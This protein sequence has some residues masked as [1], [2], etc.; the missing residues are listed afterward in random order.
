MKK[1][2]SLILTLLLLIP[3]IFYLTACKNGDE[4]P[5]TQ[6][7][8]TDIAFSGAEQINT[9]EMGSLLYVEFPNSK[10]VLSFSNYITVAESSTWSV[11][12]DIYGNIPITSKTVNLEEGDNLYYI[13]VTAAN[14]N[15][16][17]YI[18]MIHRNYLYTVNFVTGTDTEIDTIYVEEGKKVQ[19]PVVTLE[20]VL[21]NFLG[22]DWD[23]TQPITS[24]L[25]ITAKW[26]RQQGS[27]DGNE[28]VI[29]IYFRWVSDEVD[30]IQSDNSQCRV[31]VEQG[32]K[33]GEILALAEID[34]FING[35]IVYTIEDAE[36]FIESLYGNEIV[37]TFTTYYMREY[38]ISN[39][40]YGQNPSLE[41]ETNANY[42]INLEYYEIY[43]TFI[44]TNK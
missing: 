23:F 28:A 15:S 12:L 6:M 38:P 36:Y 32:T 43:L 41:V 39:H 18:I 17:Q 1:F 19:R 7:S 25:T 26:Q 31:R 20:K 33:I 8:D 35:T 29:D 5:T 27:F 37:A 22:W 14:G 24:D 10:L 34:D 42:Q 30:I 44:L 9:Q 16:K 13:L 4:P 21:Y 2:Y 11:S 3:C 40:G